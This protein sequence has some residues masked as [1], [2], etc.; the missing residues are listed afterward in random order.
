MLTESVQIKKY[1]TQKKKKTCAVNIICGIS[2]LNR[3]NVCMYTKEFGLC[4]LT[5]DSVHFVNAK[6]FY[7][8]IFRAVNKFSSPLA[9]I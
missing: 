9:L 1:E 5:N 2:V 3:T 8:C 4:C 7:V 6:P